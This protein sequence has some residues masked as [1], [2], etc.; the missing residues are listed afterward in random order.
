MKPVHGESGGATPA[1][2]EYNRIKTLP[3]APQS[4]IN[5]M[6]CVAALIALGCL[7]S[8]FSIHLVSMMT[9]EYMLPVSATSILQAIMLTIVC[10]FAGVAFLS[11]RES[12]AGSLGLFTIAF[13][14]RIVLCFFMLYFFI[15]KDEYRM[16]LQSESIADTGTWATVSARYG[17]TKLVAVFYSIFGPNILIP[18]V[19]NSLLG[20]MLPFLVYDI[21]HRLFS[22]KI[23]RRSLYF[24]AFLPPLLFYSAMNLKEIPCTFLLLL[25]IWGLYVP[26]WSLLLRVSFAFAMGIITY[27]LRAAWSVFPLTVIIFY[28]FFGDKE[29]R[30]GSLLSLKKVFAVVALAVIIVFPLRPL[31]EGTAE[32]IEGRLS[33]GI[34]ADPKALSEAKSSYTSR[35]FDIKDPWSLRN[36]SIQVLR[37]PFSPTPLSIFFDS[38]IQSIIDSLLGLTQYMLM[39]FALIGVV[40]AWRKGGV[41]T[42]CLVQL[43][44]LL[45]GGLSLMLGLTIQRIIIPMYAIISILASAGLETWRKHILILGGWFMAAAG[46]LVIYSISRL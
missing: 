25:T 2:T 30:F 41:M 14:V 40:S 1:K 4:Y 36:L 26:R 32:H 24:A 12:P 38:R 19:L 15:G 27:S 17:Y 7:I 45:T 39:P 20:S 6:I 33:I 35:L 34:Q 42:L 18:K 5:R 44:I 8:R 22:E 31:L 29:V 43:V 37:A 11:K 21:S 16:H 23:A 10:Y 13:A 46:M 3:K 9:F 28:I